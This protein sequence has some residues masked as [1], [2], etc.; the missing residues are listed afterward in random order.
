[1]GRPLPHFLS[2]LEITGLPGV[3]DCRPIPLRVN[4]YRK[5]LVGPVKGIEDLQGSGWDTPFQSELLSFPPKMLPKLPQSVGGREGHRSLLG[6]QVSGHPEVSILFC[7]FVIP[8]RLPWPTTHS[9]VF[10]PY[11][12][13]C[14]ILV[15]HD[16]FLIKLSHC[17]SDFELGTRISDMLLAL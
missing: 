3:P 14:Y 6:L 17:F 15:R 12:P 10:I 16:L 13:F 1:M 5:G 8:K 4:I 11:S 2:C 7:P 9:R